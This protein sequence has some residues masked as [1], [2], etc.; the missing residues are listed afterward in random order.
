[1]DADQ[2]TLNRKG[3]MTDWIFHGNRYRYDVDAAIDARLGSF[4]LCRGFQGSTVPLPVDVARALSGGAA[5][6]LQAVAPRRQHE[7]LS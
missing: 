1:L 3:Q 5:A 4:R 2:L 6:R 7:R